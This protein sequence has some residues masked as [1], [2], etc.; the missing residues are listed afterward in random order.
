MATPFVFAKISVFDRC[1]KVVH[2][3]TGDELRVEIGGF[4]RHLFACGGNRTDFFHSGGIQN[5]CTLTA[6][7]L[8]AFKCF[9]EGAGIGEVLLI[10]HVFFI[11]AED[12]LQNECM[13]NADIKLTGSLALFG[14]MLFH[15]GKILECMQG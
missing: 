3:K 14:E 13:Q 6:S 8:D 12:A 7:C 2:D 5:K 1:L 9:A 11:N 15:N 4:L 10:C